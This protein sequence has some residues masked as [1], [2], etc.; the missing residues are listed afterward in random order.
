MVC[1]RVAKLTADEAVIVNEVHYFTGS[2]FLKRY[3]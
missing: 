3:N 2:G 1:D